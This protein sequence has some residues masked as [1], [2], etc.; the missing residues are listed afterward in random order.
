MQPLLDYTDIIYDKSNHTNICNKIECLQYSAAVAITRAIRRS[1]KEKRCQELGFEY[2]SSRRWLCKLCLYYK[3]VVNKSPNYL[4]NCV[5]KVNQS[6]ETRSSDK[7]LHLCCRTEYF[8]NSFFP[9]TI[10]KWN[11]LIPKI[12]KS[13]SYEVFKIHY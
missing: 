9:Y 10:K 1:S 12:C 2:L 3:I 8:V 7:F 6:Y 13:L 11:N 5:S 4:C